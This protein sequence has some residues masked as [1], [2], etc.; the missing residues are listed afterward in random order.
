VR[1]AII[2][3][4][5][6]SLLLAKDER[7]VREIRFRKSSDFEIPIDWTRS[8]RALTN[9]RKQLDEYFAGHRRTFDLT[10]A[11]AG[12]DFQK[13]VW[14]ALE[15]VSFGTTVSYLEIAVRIGKPGS[16]RA[17]G[18]ANGANPIPIV[19]PC[20]R[21]IGTD[22]SLTGYG[23]GIENKRW[24]LDHEGANPRGQIGLF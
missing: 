7:G 16:V 9:V 5:I 15:S 1:Y 13:S 22:G 3:S 18:A 24:L 23:G 10:L 17:V 14:S 20:H 19:I 12:T 6:G 21:V 11:P 2:D 8:D 4:P